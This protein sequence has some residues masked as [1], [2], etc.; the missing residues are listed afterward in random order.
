M[1]RK[2]RKPEQPRSELEG[3]E[4]FDVTAPSEPQITTEYA[5]DSLGGLAE[6]D[7]HFRS[8]TAARDEAERRYLL[9]PA[10]S[11]AATAEDGPHGLGNVVGV[12]IG[13]KEI[14]GVPT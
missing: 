11:M 9:N 4:E 2:P 3:F 14:D 1:A 10:E 6:S 13:E 12:G 8:I 7:A 5:A